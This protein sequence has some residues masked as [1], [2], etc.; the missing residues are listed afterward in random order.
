[1]EYNYVNCTQMVPQIINAE[2]IQLKA[3]KIQPDSKVTKNWL[4]MLVAWEESPR[5]D[6]PAKTQYK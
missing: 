1:M 2:K 6:N 3:S 4:I 5:F